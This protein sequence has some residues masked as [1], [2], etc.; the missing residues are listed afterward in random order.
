MT[1]NNSYPA[2]T[3]ARDGWRYTPEAG[4]LA[5]RTL[6][7]TGAGSGLGEATAKTAAVY[8]ANVVLL[9]RTRKKLEA[10]FDWIE[11]NTDTQPVIVPCDLEKLT[12]PL[13]SES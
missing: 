11:A 10:V 3:E 9:G 5:G 7:V 1:D 4:A 2:L 8:G 6:L 13:K 12:P